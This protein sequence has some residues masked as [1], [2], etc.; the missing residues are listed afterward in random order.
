MSEYFNAIVFVMENIV[1]LFFTQLKELNFFE[2]IYYL[3]EKNIYSL[4]IPN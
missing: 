4:L 3:N 2:I 1:A